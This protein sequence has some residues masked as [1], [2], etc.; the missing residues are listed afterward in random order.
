MAVVAGRPI[1]RRPA[2]AAP[3][4]YPASNRARHRRVVLRE[5]ELHM[6]PPPSGLHQRLG[7]ELAMVL[8][9][10]AK[11]RGLVGSYETGLYRPGTDLDYRAR[12][13]LLPP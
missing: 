3:R 4:A 6:V 10:L 7:M 13:G 1:S 5:G 12:P 9:P 11:A 2:P 8:N